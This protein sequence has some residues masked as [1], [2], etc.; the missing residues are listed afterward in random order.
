MAMESLSEQAKR[1]QAGEITSAQLVEMALER[2]GGLEGDLR[3]WVR[4][5]RQDALSQA[6]ASDA[7]R[8][9]GELLSPIDGIPIGIKDI[10]DIEGLP[11][12]A[13][14]RLREE[15]PELFVAKAD[16]P[17]VRALREAGAVILGKTVTVEFACFDP[18][19]TRNPWDPC[20]VE[21]GEPSYTA[22]GSSSGSAAAV[23][24][25]MCS[26][27]IGTQTGGSLVR[28]S[29]YCGICS[30][31]PTIGTIDAR[32]VV[33]VT[34]FFDT[35]GPMARTVGDLR[36]VF[37][38]LPRGIV[39]QPPI[40]SSRFPHRSPPK[41]GVVGGVFRELADVDVRT[42]VDTAVEQ[43]KGEGAEVVDIELDLPVSFDEMLDVH[44][45]VMAADAAAYHL[46]DYPRRKD[47]YGPMIQTLLDKGLA[48]SAVEF[49]DAL[50]KLELARAGANALLSDCDVLLAPA[51]D[52]PAP[53]DRNTTGP[54]TFQMLWSCLGLPVVSLPCSLAKNGMPV[55]VQL[56]GRYHDDVG[57]LDCAEWC[58]RVFMFDAT[59]PMCG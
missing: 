27:A 51:T 41:I 23:A 5:E 1:L 2:I 55:A 43:L 32:G 8:E 16:A 18:S 24:A 4:G 46:S 58:E 11:T 57:V 38:Q 22:G 28:P 9:R 21:G 13:G 40:P 31:K 30:M 48:M 56:V 49:A 59:P 14:S 26:A 17:I 34:S 19:E 44:L 53:K 7:R 37:E 20:F 33:P 42:V 36:L 45:A 50:K 10:I 6:E 25:G 39:F 12:L 47:A 3:A 52:T 35:P 54:R 15:S 29:S